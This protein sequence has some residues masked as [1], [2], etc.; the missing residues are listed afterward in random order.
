MEEREQGVVIKSLWGQEHG[1][2]MIHAHLR[3]TLGA[4]AVSLPT[5]KQWMRRFR[6]GGTSGEDKS[7]LGRFSQSW[8]TF[9]QSSY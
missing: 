5:V 2:K 9:Y 1:T 4:A 8:E 6:K 7:R 3:G